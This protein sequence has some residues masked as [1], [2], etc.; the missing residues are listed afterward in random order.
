MVQ[1]WLGKTILWVFLLVSAAITLFPIVV[2]IF[3]SLKTNLELTTGATVLPAT[4]EFGNYA[5][6]W[7]TANFSR[8]TW[9]SLFVSTMTTIGSLLVAAMAAYA[10]DRASFPGKKIYTGLLAS[11]LFISIG[12]VVLRPQFDLMVQLGLQ[13]SL[14][15]VILILISAH[16]ATYF[17]MIGFLKNI[18]RELDEAAWIDGCRP[19]AVFWRIILPLLRPAL[20]VAGL[21]VFQNSWNEYILPLVFTLSNPALQTLPVGLANLRYGIGAASESQL[22]LAGACISILP[23]LAVYLFANKSFMQVTL[24]A[25]KG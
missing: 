23:L 1:K 11:T 22:M 19:S 2:V 18:P 3:G 7:K 5:T 12:A 6:A 14:W 9:N 15:G 4:W 20:A 21:S 13:K 17:M 24:G 8:F 10:V 25:V 16:A